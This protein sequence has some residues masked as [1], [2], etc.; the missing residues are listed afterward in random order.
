MDRDDPLRAE[1]RELPSQKAWRELPDNVKAQVDT[2][3]VA[4][5][6]T[7]KYEGIVS[8]S[9]PKRPL[10]P[11][12]RGRSSG[13]PPRVPGGGGDD[14]VPGGDRGRCCRIPRRGHDRTPEGHVGRSAGWSVD[15]GSRRAAAGA[16]C[17]GGRCRGEGRPG[18]PGGA[19]AGWDPV[20]AGWWAV[21]GCAGDGA[22]RPVDRTDSDGGRRG[23]GRDPARGLSDS[24]TPSGGEPGSGAGRHSWSTARGARTAH[25]PSSDGRTGSSAIPETPFPPHEALDGRRFDSLADV[26]LRPVPG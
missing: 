25:A 9:C 10:T 20:R 2:V 16:G 6:T 26:P 13:C 11:R 15:G 8:G 22:G 21:G 17:D 5:R 3:G 1:L 23:S 19:V 12:R 7:A 14:S 4:E 18:R 24:D